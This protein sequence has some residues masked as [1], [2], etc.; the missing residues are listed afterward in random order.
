MSRHLLGDG[1]PSFLDGRYLLFLFVLAVGDLLHDVLYFGVL[2]DGLGLVERGSDVAA[3]LGPVLL[4]FGQFV[5]QPL[6]IQVLGQSDGL[7]EL[8][9]VVLLELQIK[10]AHLLSHHLEVEQLADGGPLLGVG[11]EHLLDDVVQLV[12]VAAGDLLDDASGDLAVQVL[13]RAALEGRVERGHLV[14][15]AAEGED[16]ALVAVDLVVPDF[17]GEV[18]G[19]ADLRLGEVVFGHLGH[20]EVSQL[21]GLEVAG[22]EEVGRLDVAVDDLHLVQTLEADQTLA[23]VPPDG[24][25]VD[26]QSPLLALRDFAT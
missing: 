2:L 26:V 24:L 3:G 14:D 6:Q 8:I 17:G 4:L 22:E 21:D 15:D 5:L 7:D 20:V 23:E 19:R 13:Q 18:V 12:G 10:T 25:F 11:D 1:R 16:V 9:E